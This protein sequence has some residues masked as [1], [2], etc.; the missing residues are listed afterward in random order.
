[1]LSYA[2]ANEC[3]LIALATRGRGGVQRLFLGSV[4]DKV[5]RGAATPVLV[6][7]PAT[8]AFSRVL[9]ERPASASRPAGMDV[10]VLQGAVNAS[11]TL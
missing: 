2:E 7:N 10:G 1:V 8:G 11:A 9:G 6:V 3:D 4:A 5:I